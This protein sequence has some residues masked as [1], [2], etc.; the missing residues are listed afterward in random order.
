NEEIALGNVE[1]LTDFAWRVRKALRRTRVTG[2][3]GAEIDHIELF[4]PP[5]RADAHSRN[6]VLCPGKAYDRS[7]CGTGASA[8]L[9]CLAEDGKLKP[10]QPWRQEGILG[11]VFEAVYRLCDGRVVPSIRGQAFVSAEATLV[12]DPSDPFRAG[13]RG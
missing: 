7:P 5:R 11:S 9:A 2:A 6:F 10:G 13:I 8:K 12:F 1:R 4:G 3:A